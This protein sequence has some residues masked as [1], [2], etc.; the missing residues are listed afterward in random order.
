MHDETD[1]RALLQRKLDDVLA[2]QHELIAQLQQGQAY[3]QQLAR[4][5]WRVQEDERRRLA[6]AL[7][8]GVGHSLTALIHLVAQAAAAFADRP[9]EARERLA[10]ASAVAQST[11]QETRA[12]SRML[13]PQ[14]LDD[15]GLEAAL[16]WLARSFHDDHRIDV[17]LDLEQPF[18]E[19]DADLS[20]L[21]FRVAQEALTNVARH[22]RATRV[23]IAL[24]RRALHL[25]LTVG[26]DGCGCD[27][28]Q[29][30]SGSGTARSS[31]L[32]G[33][34]D[35]VRLFGGTLRVDSKPG[36]GCAVSAQFPQSGA[37]AGAPA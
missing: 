37:A 36:A 30:L 16:R 12:M 27:A 29:V 13:R 3:F 17:A 22:A 6:H 20:T 2:R 32:G 18:P 35:R 9:D 26:D 14:I 4:S 33:L 11:L 1:E 8:D 5:V 21:V 28:G 15:L 31:G 10:R 24:H 34:R 25:R 7:H 23:D 19:V